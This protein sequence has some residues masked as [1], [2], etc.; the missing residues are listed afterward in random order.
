MN[1]LMEPKGHNHVYRNMQ[2]KLTQCYSSNQLKTCQ[3]L[4]GVTADTARS[5]LN[6]C[7]LTAA[8]MKENS[9]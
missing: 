6:C 8:E 2:S 3:Q 5:S 4:K 1:R 7:P 9:L